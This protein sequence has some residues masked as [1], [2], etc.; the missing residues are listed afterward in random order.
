MKRKGKGKLWVVVFIILFIIG[1]GIASNIDII[2]E[3]YM[4]NVEPSL[5][6]LFPLDDAEIDTNTTE[7]NWTSSDANNDPITHVWYI[8]IIDTFTSP[9]LRAINVSS[10]QNY[11]PN[12]L[13]DGDW[14]WRVEASDGQE[15]NVSE[16]RHLVVKTNV[17]NNFPNLT[18]PEVN[19]L[20]GH[21]AT[22]FV[23]T[24]NFTDADN[25]TPSYIYVVI[26][27]TNYT[28]NEVDSGDI[29]TTDGKQYT[30]NTTLSFGS[31]NYSMICSDGIAVNST[32]VFNN[33][34]VYIIGLTPPTQ[35][36]PVPANE[37]FQVLIPFDNFSITINDADGQDMNISLWTNES[38]SWVMFN[39]S[40]NLSN[41]T[42]YFSNTSWVSGLGTRYWWRVCITDGIFWVNETYWFVTETLDVIC[43]YPENNSYASAQPYLTF[44]LVTPTGS[45]MNYTVFIGNSSANA[46]TFLANDSGVGN[47]SYYH[48][49]AI[50]VDV[51]ETYYW[52]VF[53]EDGSLFVNE[54][55]NFGISVA[56]GGLIAI[57]N[58]F[59]LAVA[60]GGWII[61]LAS[62]ILVVS[63]WMRNNN[64]R[65]K[66][67]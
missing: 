35:S 12:P 4:G 59:L 34:T 60:I 41:G 29:N 66:K 67:T 9:Y 20:T 52:R 7:F 24:V 56:V 40:I 54:T 27:G 22:V 19:P 10:A 15:Y 65:R 36:D 23:Y 11:T 33:P 31:H 51:N 61:G 26:D 49:H 38:G 58:S 55:F 21:Q 17:T 42:Y 43:I 5:T 62:L 45:L 28:M 37:T 3:W 53:V 48:I 44:Q 63:L 13:D 16:T 25:D 39:S 14:Y 32:A 1:L 30:Y 46:T 2:T 64:K 47:G 6:L 50:A 18:D 57:P 8:D